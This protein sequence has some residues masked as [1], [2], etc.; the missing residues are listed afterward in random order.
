MKIHVESTSP[1]GISVVNGPADNQAFL[2]VH[3]TRRTN[4]AD[5]VQDKNVILSLSNACISEITIDTEL[6]V[7]FH[8][9]ADRPVIEMVFLTS[10]STEFNFES[11]IRPLQLNRNQHN[12]FYYSAKGYTNSWQ[13]GDNQKVIT[14]TLELDR[15]VGYLPEELFHSFLNSVA[16]DKNDVLFCR[17][18]NITPQM[19]LLLEE[20]VD[21]QAAAG[22][23]RLAIENRIYELLFLQIDQY[24]NVRNNNLNIDCCTERKIRDIKNMIDAHPEHAYTMQELTQVAGL[25]EHYLRTGFKDIFQTTVHSYSTQQRMEYARKLLRNDQLNVNEVVRKMGYNDATN[26]SAAF[27]KFFGITPIQ[28]KKR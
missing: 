10:S 2:E 20:I 14:I 12:I 19:S 7:D 17:N 28:M 16:Q 24:R 18:L 13:T 6:D 1:A 25:N 27:K 11:G 4:I 9:R 21:N 3:E 15:V 26:F 5:G 8:V 23:K 22:L